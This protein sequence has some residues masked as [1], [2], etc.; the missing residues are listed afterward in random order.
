MALKV[1][2]QIK[3]SKDAVE[4]FNIEDTGTGYNRCPRLN[5]SLL[6]KIIPIFWT[7]FKEE[8]GFIPII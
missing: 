2:M 1:I 4:G 8:G 5:K 3:L 7:D 6:S